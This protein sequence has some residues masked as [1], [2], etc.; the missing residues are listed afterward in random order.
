M[1]NVM[2]GFI[3]ISMLAIGSCKKSSSEAPG[4]TP[5]TENLAG[6]YALVKVTATANGSSTEMDVTNSA[7]S[8]CKKDDITTLY[9]NGTWTLT[10]A[11]VQC[12]PPDN[13]SGN[14]LLVN[15]TT[16]Q[17]DGDL[18]TIKRFNGVNLDI[19]INDPMYGTIT[20]YLVKQ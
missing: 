18:L 8:P 10:D 3:A 17:R 2:F 4:I 19:S 6:S 11:G 20:N 5:T 12:S 16:I 14:W 9:A 1:K 15:S 13:I 7:L